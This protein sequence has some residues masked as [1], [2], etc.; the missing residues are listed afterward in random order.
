MLKIYL[1]TV[2]Y[3]NVIISIQITLKNGGHN[4]YG[5]KVKQKAKVHG[6]VLIRAW[7]H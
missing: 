6:E 5:A 4:K 2:S 3:V 7:S 1:S